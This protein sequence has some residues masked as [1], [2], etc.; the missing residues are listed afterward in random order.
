MLEVPHQL[1][2]VCQDPWDFCGERAP[3]ELIP[4]TLVWK[5]DP[6]E[7]QERAFLQAQGFGT[8]PPRSMVG[9]VC[10]S[11]IAGSKGTRG[12]RVLLGD[13][14]LPQVAV[15]S[16]YLQGFW[17]PLRFSVALSANILHLA[18]DLEQLLS[19]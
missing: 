11:S 3:C 15:V 4:W 14:R 18:S 2:C 5:A 17:S 9:D 1:L 19:Y 16:M 12:H 10:E 8:H 6:G 7:P 13:P